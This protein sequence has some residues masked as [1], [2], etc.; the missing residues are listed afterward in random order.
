MNIRLTLAV[1]LAAA[2]VGAAQPAR[3]HDPEEHDRMAPAQKAEPATPATCAELAKHTPQAGDAENAELKA[4]KGKC[5]AEKATPAK[6]T[7]APARKS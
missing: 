7:T 3:A 4:L 5:R 1:L 6:A 2:A